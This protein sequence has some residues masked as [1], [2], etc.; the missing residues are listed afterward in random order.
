MNPND[1]P[2]Q[3]QLKHRDLTPYRKSN[4]G[5]DYVHT[6]DSGKSGPHVCVNALTK[7]N[8]FCGVGAICFLLDQK[9]KPVRGKLTLSFAN[10]AAYDRFDAQNPQAN[11]FIDV[12]FNRIWADDILDREDDPASE[13]VRARQMRP[14]IRQADYL[15]D[16]LANCHLRDSA[17]WNDPP[18][19]AYIEKPS[20]S[21][22]AVKMKFPLHQIGCR[23]STQGGMLYEYGRLRDSTSTAVGLLA[24][25]GPHFAKDAEANAINI[26]LRFLNACGTID[27]ETAQA[28][29]AVGKVG[30]VNVYT[31]MLLPTAETDSFRFSGNFRGYEEF[32]KGDLIAVD[33]DKELRAPYDNCVLIALA[34]D[35]RKGDGI[36]HLIRRIET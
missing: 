5:V 27:P 8:E 19:L 30:K 33:G 36:G 34:T 3:M 15:L 6:L 12:N 29:K 9:I 26:S 25:C 23:P 35:V 17:G 14:I 18:M 16:L 10:V 20:A 4:T 32:S 13:V 11:K 7:G 1:L 21:E 22:I 2:L 31:D 28:Y 24:E